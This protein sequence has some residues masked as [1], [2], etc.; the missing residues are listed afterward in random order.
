MNGS[1]VFSM[2]YVEA[3]RRNGWETVH[4]LDIRQDSLADIK[5][6]FLTWDNPDNIDYD[7][8]ITNPPFLHAE[9]IIRKALALV[10]SESG[11]VIMLQR[12]NFL[13]SAERDD[14]F[15]KYPPS[16]IIVHAKRPSFGGIQLEDDGSI[17]VTNKGKNTTDSI[18][19][20]HFIWDN[21]DKSGNTR[22]TRIRA[23]YSKL[24]KQ[25]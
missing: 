7:L 11:K 15:T 17:N 1:S 12:L 22:F 4:T 13:G 6:D 20:A 3:L 8:I 10:D 23:D 25:R 5:E 16:R 24:K 19:Y 21:T 18:E 2:P 14:F 9:S